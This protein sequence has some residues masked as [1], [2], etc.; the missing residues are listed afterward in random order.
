MNVSPHCSQAMVI[1][2]P[3]QWLP[4]SPTNS[5]LLDFPQHAREQNRPSVPLVSLRFSVNSFPHSSQATSTSPPFQFEFFD[6]VL[7]LAAHDREQWRL[8]LVPLNVFSQCPQTQSI[9]VSP[10]TKAPL[11]CV[12]CRRQFPRR[13]TA[14]GAGQK[15]LTC[16]FLPWGLSLPLVAFYRPVHMRLY[17]I[18]SHLSSK[19]SLPHLAGRP[20][21]PPGIPLSRHSIRHTTAPLPNRSAS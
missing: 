1:G 12:G 9:I 4:V 7:L 14:T 3:C 13:K 19:S 21:A 20:R 11:I 6:P 17:H 10:K 18:P 2:P 16:R 15:R 5:R 8:L